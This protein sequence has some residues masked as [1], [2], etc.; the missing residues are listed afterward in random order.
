MPVLQG[1]N[2]GSPEDRQVEPQSQGAQGLVLRHSSGHAAGG[3]CQWPVEATGT[4]FHSIPLDSS[5]AG[6]SFDEAENQ[7]RNSPDLAALVERIRSA[8]DLVD[9][10]G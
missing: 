8:A 5:A 2:Q 10:G 1:A 9:A 6:T 3:V 7:P 4:P